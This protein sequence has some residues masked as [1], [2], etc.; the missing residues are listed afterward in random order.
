M[1]KRKKNLKVPVLVH[2]WEII[3]NLRRIWF[4]YKAENETS[5]KGKKRLERK[6]LE[7]CQYESFY[8]NLFQPKEESAFILG[9]KYIL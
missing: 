3:F 6:N 5:K 9:Q 8:V 4:P 1:G 2:F 7:S